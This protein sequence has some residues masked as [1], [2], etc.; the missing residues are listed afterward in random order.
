MEDYLYYKN[1][2]FRLK[3]KLDFNDEKKRNMLDCK[4]LGRIRLALSKLVAFN[5]KNKNRTVSLM[6]NLTSMYKQ[7]FKT[8]KV[9]LI[10]KFFNLKMLGNGNFK[11]E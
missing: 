6:T 8:N 1:L 4:V 7:P 9:H 2:Y 11:Q 3:G 5:I 10:Q